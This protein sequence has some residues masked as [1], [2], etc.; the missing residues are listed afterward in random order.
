MKSAPKEQLNGGKVMTQNE[1]LDY[2][3]RYLLAERKEYADICVPDD[4]S[5][6]RTLLRSLMN[7]RPPVPASAESVSYTHLDVYK[8]QPED[9]APTGA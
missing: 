6:K 1:R 7:V 8:R 5:E 9:R 2:L 3:L 4:L